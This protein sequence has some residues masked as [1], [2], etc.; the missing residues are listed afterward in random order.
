MEIPITNID[1]DTIS[2][3]INGVSYSYNSPET[4]KRALDSLALELRKAVHDKN[5]QLAYEIEDKMCNIE[6]NIDYM[7]MEYNRKLLVDII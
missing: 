1:F 3:D 5:I 6:Y 2:F 7:C 4:A